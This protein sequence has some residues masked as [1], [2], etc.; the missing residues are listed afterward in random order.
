MLVPCDIFR[1][2]IKRVTIG[3]GSVAGAGNVL[4][5]SIPNYS[6][7]VGVPAKILKKRRNEIKIV[8]PMVTVA[9]RKTLTLDE[10]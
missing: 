5:E 6:T 7:A 1:R 3:D 9:Y 10:Y 8:E 4:T 2:F